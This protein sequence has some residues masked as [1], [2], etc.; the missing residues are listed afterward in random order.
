MLEAGGLSRRSTP[1]TQHFTLPQTSSA[2]SSALVKSRDARGAVIAVHGQKPKP[3]RKPIHEQKPIHKRK[4]SL[5]T[6][7]KRL[8]QNKRLTPLS[9]IKSE[10]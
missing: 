2:L 3:E 4:H 1:G 10:P 6:P 5:E 9:P 7:Y 8:L